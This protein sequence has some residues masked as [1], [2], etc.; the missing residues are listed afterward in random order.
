MWA[1]NIFYIMQ[2]RGWSL[3]KIWR[4]DSTT[5]ILVILK[6]ISTILKLLDLHW[7]LLIIF[8]L[9]LPT[10]Q[11]FSFD[12]LLHIPRD[13]VLH[14]FPIWLSNVWFVHSVLPF[15]SVSFCLVLFRCC[16]VFNAV[17]IQFSPQSCSPFDHTP[18]DVWREFSCIVWFLCVI[19]MTQAVPWIDWQH[20][21]I[22]LAFWGP[23]CIFG[24][25]WSMVNVFFFSYTNYLQW[26]PCL[27][28]HERRAILFCLRGCT[29]LVLVFFNV[30][31]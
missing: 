2:A 25:C 8:M 11:L 5:K 27:R 29:G 23:A 26:V 30:G 7:M 17:S 16:E 3:I 31:K 15:L 21:L 19:F 4:I 14:P 13:F 18:F 12:V 24:P 22:T 9:L 10:H 28:L 6:F 1:H 20:H